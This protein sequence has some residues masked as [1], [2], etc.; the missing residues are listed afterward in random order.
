MCWRNR[1]SNRGRPGLF[2]AKGRR[3]RRRNSESGVSS[4]PSYPCHR[5][6][7]RLQGYNSWISFMDIPGNLVFLARHFKRRIQTGMDR[8]HRIRLRRTAVGPPGS[9]LILCILYIL[10]QLSLGFARAISV[11]FGCGRTTRGCTEPLRIFAL[12]L[13]RRH[14]YIGGQRGAAHRR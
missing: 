11:S 12:S 10:V 8:I 3:T 9:F 4:N 5:R 1:T 13:H 6:L 7:R 2:T 14:P